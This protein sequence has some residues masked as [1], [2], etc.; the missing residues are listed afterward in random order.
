M[1]IFDE[2]K[3][4]PYISIEKDLRKDLIERARK[5]ANSNVNKRHI[6][7]DMSDL[8]LLKSAGLY[9]VDSQTGQQGVTLAGIMIL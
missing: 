4:Y 1:K 6:W 2:D 5:Y 3:I 8:E 9:K 7:T